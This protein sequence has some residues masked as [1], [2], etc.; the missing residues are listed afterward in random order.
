MFPTMEQLIEHLSNKMTNEDIAK[1]YGLTFQKVIQLIKK[2]N[3]NPTELR[4]V[5]KFIVY[6]HWYNG[7]LVYVG[8]GVW[9]RCRRYTNRRNTEHRQLM[10]QGKIVYKIVGEFEDLNEARKVEAKLIKRYHSLGQVKFN[11]KINYRI[12]D[13][14]E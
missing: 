2:H 11:K 6:E 4:K 13:F 8:S 7:E 14:K 3:I 1:I 12:D 5:D 9:Y 10:E